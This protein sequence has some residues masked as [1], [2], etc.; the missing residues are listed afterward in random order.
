[1]EEDKLAYMLEVERMSLLNESQRSSR[2]FL[3]DIKNPLKVFPT[4]MITSDTIPPQAVICTFKTKNGSML[5]RQPTFTESTDTITDT[6]DEVYTEISDDLVVRMKCRTLEMRETMMST[7]RNIFQGIGCRGITPQSIN[8]YKEDSVSIKQYVCDLLSKVY[9]T[10]SMMKDECSYVLLTPDKVKADDVCIFSALMQVF[11]DPYYRSFKGFIVLLQ[12]EF[13]AFSYDITKD[14]H[15]NVFFF[16]LFLFSLE[17]L[18]HQ[19]ITEFEYDE[20]LLQFICQCIFSRRFTTF[21]HIF[22]TKS[23]LNTNSL[24][25]YIYTNSDK[26]R[27]ILYNPGTTELMYAP[28]PINFFLDEW[29]E[30]SEENMCIIDPENMDRKDWELQDMNLST[31]PPYPNMLS[32]FTSLTSLDLSHNNFKEFPVRLCVL[33]QLRKLSLSDNSISFV[34]D[35][36][37]KLQNLESLSLSCNN[38]QTLPSLKNLPL[39]SLDIST[40]KIPKKFVQYNQYRVTY[41][42][43]HLQSQPMSRDIYRCWNEGVPCGPVRDAALKGTGP[44]F[45]PQLGRRHHHRDAPTSVA[46]PHDPIMPNQRHP[47]V[48]NDVAVNTTGCVSQHDSVHSLLFLVLA[49]STRARSS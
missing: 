34:T 43:L 15:T 28:L 46:R 7:T 39:R 20:R 16:V 5:L 18:I 31:F 47:R 24:L 29:M 49:V 35:E 40:N 13:G 22:Q 33:T 44:L 38:I 4:V 48:H 42:Q 8:Q 41:T 23:I 12:K 9:Y 1:M 14:E 19:N 30:Y 21:F 17:H 32:W 6:S 26:Y 10:A 3:K 2:S 25:L 45:M 11:L 27:N 37:S 36:I